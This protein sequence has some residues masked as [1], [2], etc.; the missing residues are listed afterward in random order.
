MLTKK[1]S[2]NQITL[3]KE[4]VEKIPDTEYFEVKYERGRIIL[5]PVNIVPA[6]PV[7]HRIREKIKKQG[8]TQKEVKE[9]IKWARGRSR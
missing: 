1:T 5:I 2:K 9:A 8:V 4:I 7:I 6:S 3:P